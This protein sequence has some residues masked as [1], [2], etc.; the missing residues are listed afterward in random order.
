MKFST[1][2]GIL[3]MAGITAGAIGGVAMFNPINGLEVRAAGASLL[4]SMRARSPGDRGDGAVTTKGLREPLA[5][6]PATPAV[7]RVLSLAPTP[8]AAAPA[9][10]VAAVAPLVAAPPPAAAIVPAVLAP[11]ALPVIASAVP[12]G[13]AGFLP[14]IPIIAGG[15]GGGGIA[16]S[17]PPGVT[18]VPAVPEPATWAMMIIGFGSI[19][20]F[21]RRRKR[22]LQQGD[23]REAGSVDWAGAR[24]Q[25][26]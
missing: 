10:P 15:G 22:Q 17:A 9:V 4:G 21:L 6:A 7:S 8:A 14:L 1:R 19:G 2:A 3:A 25:I 16:V 18:P 24:A 23:G 12:S 11:A 20:A 26:A 13:G 5:Q